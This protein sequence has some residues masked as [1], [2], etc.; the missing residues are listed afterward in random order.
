MLVLNIIFIDYLNKILKLFSK[1]IPHWLMI[2]Q[3]IS[4]ENKYNIYPNSP[5]V[6]N[7]LLIT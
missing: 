2:S 4:F 3:S 7:H 6:M 1:L 5:K